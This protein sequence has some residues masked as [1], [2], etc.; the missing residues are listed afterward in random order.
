MDLTTERFKDGFLVVVD[1]QSKFAHCVGGEP[2]RKGTECPNCAKPLYQYF[3][4]DTRDERLGLLQAPVEKLPLLYC[5]RCALAWCR[6]SYRVLPHGGIEQIE[7]HKG[8]RSWDEFYSAVP[9]DVFPRRP[10]ELLPLPPRLASLQR[11]LNL[12]QVLGVKSEQDYER[13]IRANWKPAYVGFPPAVNLSQI[14]GDPYLM[15]GVKPPLCPW[16]E[17]STPS[18][19]VPAMHFL[20]TFGNQEATGLVFTPPE[21][22]VIFFICPDCFTVSVEHSI[23]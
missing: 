10:I 6:F 21:Y 15:Q 7:S 11:R 19:D 9:L 3:E 23:D 5:L 12:T 20:A 4:L 1:H 2:P 17:R 13:L 14:R 18:G 8:E 22:Q 16:C